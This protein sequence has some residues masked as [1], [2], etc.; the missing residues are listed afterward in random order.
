MP[1][2]FSELALSD[3]SL[4]ALQLAGPEVGEPVARYQTDLLELGWRDRWDVAFLLDV[5][6]HIPSDREV[7][8]QIVQALKPG[9]LLFVTTPALKYFWSY[10]DEMAH[11]VRRYSKSD[12]GQLARASGLLLKGSWY[13]MFLLS[14]LLLLRRFRRPRLEKMT[15]DEIFDLTKR[16]HRVPSAPINELLRL[17]FSLETPAGLRM[18][19]PWGT[20]ILGVFQKPL[21]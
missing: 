18:P 3:S 5:L 11:H 4:R 14:P 15:Q 12:F 8:Q 10:N 16:T 1:G 6:E 9:G 19:F 2:T 20:S 7:L 13:F 17:V 21:S